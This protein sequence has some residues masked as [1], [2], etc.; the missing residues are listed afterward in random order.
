MRAWISL[1]SNQENPIVQLCLALHQ[2]SRAR[3]IEIIRTS[4]FYRTAPWGKTDQPA[5][6][7]AVTIV[8]TGLEPSDLLNELLK[9]EHQMGRQR[10]GDRWG[11]RCIDLDLL[12]Y[13]EHRLASADLELPHPR[14]HLRAFVLKPIL[15]LDSDFVIPGIGPA[16]TRLDALED[17]GVEWLGAADT[18][19]KG[20][21]ND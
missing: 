2:M 4:G 11:P 18:L 8:E 1:G 19:C 20:I 14:M 15:E 13:N 12:T 5:F 17:Q 7:N 16:A 21:N 3:G 9:I 6:V 10:S